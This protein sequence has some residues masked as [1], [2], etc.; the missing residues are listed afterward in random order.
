LFEKVVK[1]FRLDP[2]VMAKET[3]GGFYNLNLFQQRNRGLWYQE[4][5]QRLWVGFVDGLQYHQ[6][7]TWVKFNDPKTGEPLSAHQFTELPDGTLCIATVD[8]GLFF[9]KMDI[10][11]SI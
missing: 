4:K 9:S 7:G 10:L 6:N 1:E 11:P 8:Q 5:E 2:A 3:G